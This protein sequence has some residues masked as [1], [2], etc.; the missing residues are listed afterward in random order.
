[1]VSIRCKLMVKDEL[2]KLGLNYKL[3]ELGEVEITEVLSA[4]QREQLALGLKRSGLELMDDKKAIL[5]ERI[6]N[7]IV[8]VIHY[9]DEALK[10]NFS[11]HLSAELNYDYT[12]LSNLFSEVESSTIE[13]FIIK[14]KIERAKELLI[15]DELTLTQIAYKL[16]YSSV[17][18]LSNQFKKITGLT[19]TFFKDLRHKRLDGLENV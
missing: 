4:S 14:H 18:H 8:E 16:H 9:S 19:P 15:Y 1:M 10:I 13:H 17:A 12:Y 2:E 11:D 7:V 6:K 5:I 3:V